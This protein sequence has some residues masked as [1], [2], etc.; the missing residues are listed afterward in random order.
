[1][2]G[3]LIKRV[4]RLARAGW[5]LVAADLAILTWRHFG[6]LSGEE[7]RQLVLL[8]ARAMRYRGALARPDRVELA[9]LVMKLEPRLLIGTA[10]R[11]VSPVPLPARLLYGRR[12]GPA[13]RL[14]S[15]GS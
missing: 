5:P 15:R 4:R 13:R 11:R 10:V 1:M 12:S 2:G 14:L 8:T 7:R 6:R 3:S 9:S